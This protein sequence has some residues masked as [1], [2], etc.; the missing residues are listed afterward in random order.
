MIE[1][2]PYQDRLAN[3]IRSAFSSGA[4]RPLAVSPT[5]SGK[6]VLFSY[7]TSQVL[8]R[9]SRVMIVAHRRE[10]LDQISATL[11][12][13]SVPHGFIQAGKP[14]SKQA[15]MVA[16]IQT[17]GRRLDQVAPPDLVIIDECFVRG[18]MI[19]SVP[20]EDIRPGMNVLGW[21]GRKFVQE[22][23]VRLYRKSAMRLVTIRFTCG[24]VV[25]C[26]P[27]HPFADPFGNW[28]N[29][30][31]LTPGMMVATV[32]GDERLHHLPISD[33]IQEPKETLRES[34]LQIQ[35]QQPDDCQQF[36]E[37]R[38][39][40]YSIQKIERNAQT[41]GSREGFIDS[42]S[43]EVEARD[44]W[45]KRCYTSARAAIT[46]VCAWVGNGSSGKDRKIEDI[47]ISSGLQTG[48]CQRAIDDRSRSGRPLAQCDFEEKSGREKSGAVGVTW[49]ESVEIHERGG[50]GRFDEVCPDGL[51]YNFETSG[52]HTYT[53]E[54]IIVH[55]CHHAVSKTYIEVFAR[56]PE[57]KFIG[58]T[59]TPERLDGKGL[60]SMFD[61]MV[62]GPSVQ[63]LIDNGFLARPVYYAPRETP[64]LSHVHKVAGDFDRAETE[65]IIDTP[66]ITGDAVIHY[67]R[68]CGGQR[69]VAFCISVAHAQHVAEQ[70]CAAGVPAASIDGSLDPE[71]RAQ[72]VADLTAGKILVLTSCELISEGFDL[73]AVNAAILLRPT[74]SLSMHLQQLGRALRP[75]PGKT[76]AT[77]LDHV[78]NCLRHGLAEQ[79]RAWDLE[80]REKRTKKSTPV[81]TKQCSKCFAIF[82]GTVCPQCGQQREVTGR[83]VEEVDGELQRLSIEDIAAKREARREEGKCRTL[84]DFKALARERGYKPG[85]A[86]FR[87]QARQ[88]KSTVL[89]HLL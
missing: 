59:A 37:A 31:G 64:D 39:R 53:A 77:I 76:H 69:A 65:E 46:R 85:W 16:S 10:I 52:S 30:G 36:Q 60:G 26:T 50:A 11:K 7:I 43:N 70:F 48:Y 35:V 6:T 87:W 61:R 79:E 57:A 80:G 42:K 2:R 32:L 25:T 14:M 75:Y 34:S 83:E 15:A 66:R 54:G 38:R 45:W 73:P 21:D 27:N 84:E 63:W 12:R 4:R 68:F 47:G 33:C 71:V 13:V 40:D 81:E 3:D 22:T 20:I 5:G 82:T 18:T 56:W 89:T 28:V 24:R 55:N 74:H 17:L 23:V 86:Y 58:V 44:S 29:A 67:R 51:V 49:V 19:G 78:G 8:K 88:R 1:L 72:R 41:R 62:M 9:G